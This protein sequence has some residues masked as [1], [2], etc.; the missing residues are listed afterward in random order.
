MDVEEIE[1]VYKEISLEFAKAD[2]TE[3]KSEKTVQ[4]KDGAVEEVD[5]E[6]EEDYDCNECH[7]FVSRNCDWDDGKDDE[8]GT[9]GGQSGGPAKKRNV[10]VRDQVSKRMAVGGKKSGLLV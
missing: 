2:V 6:D 8:G 3:N 4:Q 7:N 9:G 10:S 5:E 1:A